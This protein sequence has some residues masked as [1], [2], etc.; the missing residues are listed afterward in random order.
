MSGYVLDSLNIDGF[1]LGVPDEASVIAGAVS[2][3]LVSGA[4]VVGVASESRLGGT[5]VQ[6][7]PLVELN[8]VVSLSACVPSLC[9]DDSSSVI[10]YFLPLLDGF[11][12]EEPPT[13][14]GDARL[15]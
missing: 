9:A 2:A 13:R 15:R 7:L 8:S 5:G 14:V 11:R 6:H 10:R 1:L 12:C 3:L 4:A